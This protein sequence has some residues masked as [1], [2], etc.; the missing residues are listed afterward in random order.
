MSFNFIFDFYFFLPDFFLVSIFLFLILVFVVLSSL[1]LDN[2]S[3]VFYPILV[4]S[5]ITLFFF[6]LGSTFPLITQFFSFFFDYYDYTR[7]YLGSLLNKLFSL[8]DFRLSYLLLL[9][10]LKTSQFLNFTLFFNSL[11]F[12]CIFIFLKLLI[13]FF[14]SF[15]IL[16]CRDYFISEKLIRFESIFIFFLAF[17]GCFFLISVASFCLSF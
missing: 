11:D 15:F 14:F 6:C 9:S 12:G 13:L 17:L 7:F 10:R 16:I 1:F 2:S 4:S 8:D 5:S 3:L